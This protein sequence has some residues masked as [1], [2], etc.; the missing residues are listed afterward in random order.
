MKLNDRVLF[1]SECDMYVCVCVYRYFFFLSFSSN[2]HTNA[3][4]EHSTINELLI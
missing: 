1:V 4:N 3:T 2:T